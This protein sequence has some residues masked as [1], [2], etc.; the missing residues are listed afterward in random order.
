MRRGS[1]QLS[2]SSKDESCWRR[3]SWME[4]LDGFSHPPSAAV[5]RNPTSKTWRVN[6]HGSL[7]WAPEPQTHWRL[8]DPQFTTRLAS[9]EASGGVAAFLPAFQEVQYNWCALELHYVLVGGDWNITFIFPYIEKI[10]IPIDFHIFQG[11]WNHLPWRCFWLI[12]CSPKIP[13][14]EIWAEG[15][16]R[17][18]GFL[19]P[20]LDRS[21]ETPR[22]WIRKDLRR[23]TR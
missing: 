12:F 6:L 9:S 17:T 4:E 14:S 21:G 13:S 8:H 18:F 22:T 15:I 2:P 16:R 23:Y 11:C 1:W 19:P 3:T 5:S 20:D 10:I 7:S